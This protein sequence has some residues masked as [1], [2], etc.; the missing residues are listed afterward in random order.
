MSNQV[1]T[2]CVRQ[3]CLDANDVCLGC[4]RTLEEILA[5]QAMSEEERKAAMLV[6]GARKKK[7]LAKR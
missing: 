5:W 1:T 3:C 4:F 6:I 7:I 2:P